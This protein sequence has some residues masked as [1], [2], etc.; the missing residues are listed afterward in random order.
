MRT[1][2]VK[3]RTAP[4]A[5]SAVF[6]GWSSVL[7]V[8]RFDLSGNRNLPWSS[9]FLT[10]GFICPL[11]SSLSPVVVSPLHVSQLDPSRFGGAS[12]SLAI[13]SPASDLHVQSE[14]YLSRALSQFN[15]AAWFSCIRLLPFSHAVS[16]CFFVDRIA[17]RNGCIGIHRSMVEW[18]C[19][20][21]GLL[22]DAPRPRVWRPRWARPV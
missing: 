3:T 12:L 16:R 8:L 6:P 7:L 20:N 22:C 9:L 19:S 13:P 17:M 5:E 14:L 18:Q 1:G 15:G 10:F 2:A 21:I 4:A 11:R